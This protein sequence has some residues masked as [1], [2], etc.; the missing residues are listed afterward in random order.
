MKRSSTNEVG[1]PQPATFDHDI[2]GTSGT[3]RFPV[4]P[5]DSPCHAI[6]LNSCLPFDRI[7]VRTHRSD[8]EV[9]VL[10]GSSG[11]VLVRGGRYFTTFRRA[12]LAGSTFGG[13]A[14]RLR[15]IEVGGQL[16]LRVDGHPIVTSTIEAVSRTL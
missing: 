11:Q 4:V 1:T 8:Y 15:S 7:A 13:S 2:D 14:I 9:V 12:A 3:S 10:P 6:H 5:I 16:E